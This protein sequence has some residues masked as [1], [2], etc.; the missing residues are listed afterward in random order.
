MTVAIKI[1]GF[2]RPED[3][4]AA[5]E[6][7]VDA[8]G[9]VLADDA[10]VHLTHAQLTSLIERIPRERVKAIAVLGPADEAQAK[11]ALAL[12]FDRL[13]I[14][15]KPEQDFSPSIKKFVIPVYFDN[16]DV[17]SQVKAWSLPQTSTRGPFDCIT[18]DG[19]AGG[20]KGISADHSR[21]AQCAVTH[22]IMLAGGLRANNVA[23]AI[24]TVQPVAVDVSSG[25]ESAPG[26]KC[27]EKMQN[28]IE[29][30]RGLQSS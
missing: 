15:V 21:V 28:F 3:I 20:G 1:C 23:E 8:I 25:V 2:T 14:V 10:H 13:Q 29:A 19:P 5:V 26:I 9:L 27:A 16:S 30:V 6:L 12:G 11:E 4:D 17:Y 18:I 24:K 22:P 7:G